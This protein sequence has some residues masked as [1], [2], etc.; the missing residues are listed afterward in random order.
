MSRNYLDLAVDNKQIHAVV[1]LGA[2]YSAISY[3]YYRQ[4]RKVMLLAV[5]NVILKVVHRNNVFSRFVKDFCQRTRPLQILLKEAAKRSWGLEQRN[6]WK[7]C[8]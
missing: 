4:V 5:K 8:K 7:I 6:L 2:S 1:D 3:N